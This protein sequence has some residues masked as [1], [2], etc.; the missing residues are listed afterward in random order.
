MPETASA[1]KPDVPVL[2][3][4]PA[5]FGEL[6]RL[7]NRSNEDAAAAHDQLQ[8]LYAPPSDILAVAR[9]AED[10]TRLLRLAVERAQTAAIARGES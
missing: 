5:Y 4:L 3:P 7:A 10:A 1:V 9:L 8:K 2:P 6:W